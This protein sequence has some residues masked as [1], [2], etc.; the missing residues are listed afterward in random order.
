[1][2][3]V[4]V[5]GAPETSDL[6]GPLRAVLDRKTAAVSLPGFGTPRPSGFTGSKDAYAGWL[7]GTLRGMEP[8]L[9]VVGHDFGALLTMRVAT[10]LDVP[11]RSWVVDVP[12]IF[13]PR[14]EWPERLSTGPDRP[15][16]V[17]V[18]SR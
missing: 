8:P 4:F 16:A 11:L 12:D 10:A 5:H 1:M 6:W 14:A 2:T 17:R 3:V 18:R 7:A 9:D 15:R 13:H